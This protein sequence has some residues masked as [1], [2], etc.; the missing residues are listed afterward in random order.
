MFN[1]IIPVYTSRLFF[2]PNSELLLYTSP[3]RVG[4]PGLFFSFLY[5]FP[6]AVFYLSSTLS[7]NPRTSLIIP[8]FLGIMSFSGR[9]RGP[10]QRRRAVCSN[11][12]SAARLEVPPL[13][14]Y[15]RLHM[16]RYSPNPGLLRLPHSCHARNSFHRFHCLERACHFPFASAGLCCVVHGRSKWLCASGFASIYGR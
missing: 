8:R 16:S 4:H 3:T 5:L 15:S 7:R 14:K 9:D 6:S 12:G 1:G 10:S 13:M 11:S 2:L